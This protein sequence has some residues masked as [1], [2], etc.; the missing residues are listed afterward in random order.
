[1]SYFSKK[2]TETATLR[3][4]YLGVCQQFQRWAMYLVAEAVKKGVLQAL[5]AGMLRHDLTEYNLV[6]LQLELHP[7]RIHMLKP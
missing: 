7:L 5:L 6:L 4:A 1:M 2:F 3:W